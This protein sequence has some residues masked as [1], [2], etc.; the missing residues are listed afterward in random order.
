MQHI[1]FLIKIRDDISCATWYREDGR[2]EEITYKKINKAIK[3]LLKNA[4]GYHSDINNSD[5]SDSDDSE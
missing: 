5:S 2:L 4:H 1:H 3:Y